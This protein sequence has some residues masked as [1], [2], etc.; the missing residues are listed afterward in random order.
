M[1][2]E[3]NVSIMHEMFVQIEWKMCLYSAG[4]F[5][6]FSRMITILAWTPFLFIYIV[7]LP[8]FS[9]FCAIDGHR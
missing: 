2:N 1:E 8:T 5:F 9:M 3:M 6:F 4:V 7:F